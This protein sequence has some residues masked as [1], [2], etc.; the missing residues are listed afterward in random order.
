MRNV[1][2]MDKLDESEIAKTSE[3]LVQRIEQFIVTGKGMPYDVT[4]WNNGACSSADLIYKE[5]LGDGTQAN[6]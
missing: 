1:D 2:F 4:F 5:L 3:E 6:G